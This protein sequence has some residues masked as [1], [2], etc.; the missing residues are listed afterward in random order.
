MVTEICM[1][2]YACLIMRLNMKGIPQMSKQTCFLEILYLI[3][4]D[5]LILLLN[6]IV[7]IKIQEKVVYIFPLGSHNKMGG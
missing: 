5:P 6:A 4:L 2:H 3:L 7:I 1:F